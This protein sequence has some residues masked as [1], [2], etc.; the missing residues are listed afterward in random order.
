MKKLII[1]N[2]LLP[3]G[4]GYCAP[5][6]AL[7]NHFLVDL[8]HHLLKDLDHSLGLEYGI[9]VFRVFFNEILLVSLV[10]EKSHRY[11]SA[12]HISHA[13]TLGIHEFLDHIPMVGGWIKRPVH[14]K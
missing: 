9:H 4:V 12:E 8:V 2:V 7:A 6:V 14:V 11:C 1:F 5:S 3:F 13:V 10:F